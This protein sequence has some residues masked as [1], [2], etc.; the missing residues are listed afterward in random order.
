MDIS[1]RV[2][3]I[4]ARSGDESSVCKAHL[5]PRR[6]RSHPAVHGWRFEAPMRTWLVG[7]NFWHAKAR[8][9]SDSA[10]Q[11][12]WLSR[13]IKKYCAIY[14]DPFQ[15]VGTAKAVRARKCVDVSC[16]CLARR[17]WTGAIRPGLCRAI[18][19]FSV[20]SDLTEGDLEKLGC[21]G[22]TQRLDRQC[23]AL[24]RSKSS[25]LL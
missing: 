9:A 20:I 18:H 17:A 5:W 4:S 7:T 21:F 11:I 14:E 6:A 24:A 25:S 3:R 13:A 15:R 12:L 16:G 23:C 10:G 1:A 2:R 22:W 8:L 19:R